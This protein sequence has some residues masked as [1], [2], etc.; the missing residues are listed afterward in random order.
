MA[1]V[2]VKTKEIPAKTIARL[3]QYRRAL[4]ICLSRG[5]TNIFSHEIASLQHVT[6]VQVRRD[7]MLIGFSGSLKQGYDI[8]RLIEVISEILDSEEGI[9][10]AVVGLGNLGRAMINYFY[11]KRT[12]LTIVAAFDNDSNKIG[13]EFNGIYCYSPYRLEEVIKKKNIKIAILTVPPEKA[14]EVTEKLVHA[15]I[16]G[17]LNYTSTPVNVPDHVFLDEY[18]MIT[19]LEKAAFFVKTLS[20]NR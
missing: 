10:V 13:T 15:G 1:K 2:I 18:D 8:H 6:P 9:N 12:R 4:L 17:I 20:E 7:L 5:K 19:T 14:V 11:G 3:S 16:T